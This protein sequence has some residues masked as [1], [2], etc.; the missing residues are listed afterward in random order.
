VARNFVQRHQERILAT[1]PN[2]IKKMWIY[3]R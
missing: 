1:G 3:H 2:A